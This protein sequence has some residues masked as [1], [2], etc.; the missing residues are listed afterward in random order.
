MSSHKG[1]VVAQGSGTP[2]SN[3]ET[4]VVELTEQGPLLE[5][6]G[7]R[8]M[9]NPARAKEEQTCPGLQEEEEEVWALLLSLQAHHPRGR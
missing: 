5:E 2:D 4:D 7:M 8:V 9:P 6:N 1:S 3:G